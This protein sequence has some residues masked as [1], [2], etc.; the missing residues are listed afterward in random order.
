MN[1]DHPAPA[2]PPDPIREPSIRSPRPARAVT[3]PPPGLRRLGRISGPMAALVLLGALGSGAAFGA[4]TPGSA[5]TTRGANPTAPASQ[6][7]TDGD[8][9]PDPVSPDP[10]PA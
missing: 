3:T 1:L 6:P 7:A 4:G 5:T 2:S 10:E 9:D 8:D